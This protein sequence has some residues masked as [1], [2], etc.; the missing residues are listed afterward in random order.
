[1]RRNVFGKAMFSLEL[2]SIS[3]QHQSTPISFNFFNQSIAYHSFDIVN[4]ETA[5]N[6]LKPNEED[7]SV[8][9]DAITKRQQTMEL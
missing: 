5:S 2:S 9:S 8:P 4:M 6:R 3:Q 7:P 1:M